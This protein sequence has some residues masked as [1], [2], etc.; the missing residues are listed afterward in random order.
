MS[1]FEALSESDDLLKEDTSCDGVLDNNT[2]PQYQEK[3]TTTKKS[4]LLNHFTVKSKNNHKPHTTDHNSHS[5]I[6]YPHS[7]SD[8]PVLSQEEIDYL[9]TDSDMDSWFDEIT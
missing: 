8:D 6:S 2:S 9:F 5:E 4:T 3:C 7:S 1:Y